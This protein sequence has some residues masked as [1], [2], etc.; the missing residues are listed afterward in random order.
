MDT[1]KALLSKV[2]V[3]IGKHRVSVKSG[4]PQ[5]GIASPALFNIGSE[6]I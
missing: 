1:L 4:V 2:K 6:I 5:G 3:K